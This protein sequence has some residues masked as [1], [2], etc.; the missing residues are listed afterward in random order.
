VRLWLPLLFIFIAVAGGTLTLLSAAISAFETRKR[1]LEELR[2]GRPIQ[3]TVTPST[4]QEKDDIDPAPLLSG[5]LQQSPMGK[6]LQLAILQAGLVW[7]PSEFIALILAAALAG[8]MLGF[9]VGGRSIVMAGMAAV[10]GGAV[11]YVYLTYQQSKRQSRLSAQIPDMLD[12]LSASL[13]S[14]HSFLSGIQIVVSQMQPPISDEFARVVQEVKF[15]AA[16]NKA[17]D[18]LIHRTENYDMEL[19]IQAVQTQLSVGGNLA[20]ILDKIGSMIRD[21]VKLK[22]EIDAATAEGRFSAMILVGMP[23]L[24]AFIVNAI[25]PGYLTPLF[26][27]TLGRIMLAGAIGLLITGILIIRSMLNLDM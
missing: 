18:D 23:F 5:L 12:I 14:G 24:M 1:R 3:P 25:S 22:G 9:F 21:R 19:I 16:L 15:G 7:R 20:E 2:A 17:L 27:D 4:K 13:R 11:P 10:A 8:Y 26:V 6:R